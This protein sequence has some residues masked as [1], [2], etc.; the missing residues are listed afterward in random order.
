MRVA[1]VGGGIAGLSAAWAARRAGADV[2][3]LFDRPG[4]SSLYSGALDVSSWE[5]DRLDA[6]IP[7]GVIALA[8]AFDAW[9][10]GIDGDVLSR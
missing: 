9:S 5:Q 10:L 3:V 4:A 8:T 6:P 7:A 1:V 2:T